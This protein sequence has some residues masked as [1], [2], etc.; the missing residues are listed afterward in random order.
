MAAVSAFS[1]RVA[2]QGLLGPLLDA[3]P[4]AL[5]EEV[6]LAVSGRLL[7]GDRPEKEDA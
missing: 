7:A 4:D 2:S 6:A 3:F 1:D 5:F